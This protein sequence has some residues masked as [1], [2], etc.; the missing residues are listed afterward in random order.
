[1]HNEQR[2]DGY[3]RDLLFDH[4]CV[5]VMDLG[6]F[7]AHYHPASINE[8]LRLIT[9]P[10]KR[11]AFN[12][13]LR[14]NDGLLAH[15]ISFRESLSYAEA[16]TL[17]KEYASEIKS[18]M[19]RGGKYKLDKVGVLFQD[20]SGNVQFLPDTST[21]FLADSFGLPVV[22]AVP[23]KSEEVEVDE[24]IM[25]T[26]PV[27]IE[28]DQRAYA[29]EETSKV[30]KLKF[31]EVI[32]AAAILALL[33]MAPPIIK[34]FNT[35]MGSLVP[36]SRI[37]EMVSGEKVVYTP[38]PDI[39]IMPPA[40]MDSTLVEP[41]PVVIEEQVLDSISAEPAVSVIENP[42]QETIIQSVPVEEEA[43]DNSNRISKKSTFI[44]YHVIVGSFKNSRNAR[45][46]SRE[47]R[48]EQL[49][50]EIIERTDGR[51]MV[52]VYSSKSEREAEQQLPFFR[53]KVIDSAW[54][55]EYTERE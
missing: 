47:L 40:E 3:I 51:H 7:I 28:F 54:V 23:V 50:A 42:S 36:F 9:P 31:M 45:R 30:R 43:D 46:L 16:C 10:S 1:M 15:H 49:D 41:V 12:A 8:S 48:R 18:I 38:M 6:G 34:K 14:N 29:S 44:S 52:S 5:I 53:S 33:I 19:D 4:D 13:A 17:V 2:L 20:H 22:H 26:E 37:D 27:V 32:P 24:Q 39:Q 11:I 55:F 35:H 21:N 25:E